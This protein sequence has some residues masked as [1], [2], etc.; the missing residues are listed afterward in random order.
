MHQRKIMCFAIRM[1]RIEMRRKAIAR[2][3]K[4]KYNRQGVDFTIVTTRFTE[5]EYDA[6]HCTAHALRVSV[7]WLVYKIILL[8]QKPS[9]RVHP[10]PFVTNYEI[11]PAYCGQNGVAFSE[12]LLIW[13]K[14][15]RVQNHPLL[16]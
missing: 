2:G 3:E 8:W 16:L 7:S 12:S 14:P 5:A 13:R 10:N 4:I 9:R 15:T 1:L 6:L 11:Y